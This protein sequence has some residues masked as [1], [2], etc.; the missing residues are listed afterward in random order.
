[1]LI[2]VLI[3]HFTKK[4]IY[5]RVLTEFRQIEDDGS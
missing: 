5:L 3:V 1:V 2:E 4:S